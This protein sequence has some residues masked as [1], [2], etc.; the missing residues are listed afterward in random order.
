MDKQDR[1]L[2]RFVEFVDE[3]GKHYRD[4]DLIPIGIT[5]TS[6]Y[7]EG[8]M[9]EKIYEGKAKILYTTEEAG[10]IVQYFKDD[11]T[12][13]NAQKKG[14]FTDKGYLNNIISEHLMLFMER[15]GI[16]THFIQRLNEREQ[17]IKKVKI[18]PVEFIVRNIAAGSLCSRLGIEEGI[19]LR[20]ADGH[21]LIEFCLKDDDLNDPVIGE[22]HIEYF[23]FMTS[24]QIHDIKMLLQIINEKL[25]DKF[26]SIGVKL[27]DYK[28]EFGWGEVAR[29]FPLLADEICPDTCRL[30]D[31]DTG[32]ILDKDRF[33]K[34]LGG[35]TDAYQEI[36]RRFGLI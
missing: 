34:D 36:A 32:K 19:N 28:L 9:R 21:P 22:T 6:I 27:V 26:G 1:R 25:V 23:G 13:F 11:A 16:A 29:I 14:S 3:N 30:W 15:E 7:E 20:D 17:L 12:A 24:Q 4:N 2:K 5:L 35:E 33:R 10:R 31:K 8:E 18:I